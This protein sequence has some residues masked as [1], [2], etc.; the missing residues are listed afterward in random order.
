MGKIGNKIKEAWYGPHKSFIRYATYAT[1][2]FLVFEC[3]I[4]D[5]SLLR[6]AKA[7]IEIRQQK[8]APRALTECL[9]LRHRPLHLAGTACRNPMLVSDLHYLQPP[10]LP[11]SGLY[12]C[13]RGSALSLTS[14]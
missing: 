6:W 3:F 13:F 7:G 12:N 2:A 10:L 9:Y 14:H 11:A 4:S 8:A 1:A 5:D